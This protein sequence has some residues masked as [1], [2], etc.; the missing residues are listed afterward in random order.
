[1]V[2]GCAISDKTLMKEEDIVD[3]G[4]AS[5]EDNE[6]KT[7]DMTYLDEYVLGSLRKLVGVDLL[8]EQACGWLPKE[9]D[10]PPADSVPPSPKASHSRRNSKKLRYSDMHPPDADGANEPAASQESVDGEADADADVNAKEEEGSITAGRKINHKRKR[11]LRNSEAAAYK[12]ATPDAESEEED[13]A[14]ESHSGKK[15]AHRKTKPR[16]SEADVST[17]VA[18]GPETPQSLSPTSPPSTTGDHS[19]YEDLGEQSDSPDPEASQAAIDRHKRRKRRRNEDLLAYKP[20]P[21]TPTDDEESDDLPKKKRRRRTKGAAALKGS[22]SQITGP[23]G[24]K[25]GGEDEEEGG[26]EYEVEM[27]V[28]MDI[29]PVD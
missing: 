1:V 6:M 21:T 9:G 22:K 10:I 11:S 20:E 3:M 23:S 24:H 14:D 16:Q 12:P 4:E 13:G 29:D 25:E 15:K 18:L 8:H 7:T 26:S 5:N 2:P 17:E 27:G 28:E 19:E